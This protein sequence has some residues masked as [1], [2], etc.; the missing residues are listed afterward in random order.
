MLKQKKD[1]IEEAKLQ[2]EVLSKECY[3]KTVEPV[4]DSFFYNDEI[5]KAYKNRY[6]RA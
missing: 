5:K 3:A 2:A 4:W 1:S 6:N